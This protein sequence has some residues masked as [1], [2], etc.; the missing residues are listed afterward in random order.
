MS[1]T[2]V[3]PAAVVRRKF[4]TARTTDSVT[5]RALMPSFDS[6]SVKGQICVCMSIMPGRM[7][8]P[9]TSIT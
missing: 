9:L 6:A 2:V 3:M 8:R 5:V 4:S 7:V 1:R